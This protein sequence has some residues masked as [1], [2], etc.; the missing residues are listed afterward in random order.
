MDLGSV[1]EG[2]LEEILRF[3]GAKDG[4]GAAAAAAL[5]RDGVLGSVR[6]DVP[7]A[8][9]LEWRAALRLG[10]ARERAFAFDPFGAGMERSRAGR[11]LRCWR[12]DVDFKG[13]ARPF[14]FYRFAPEWRADEALA[15]EL[16]SE[17]SAARR[18]FS[19]MME[20]SALPRGGDGTVVLV[21][22][23][24]TDLEKSIAGH[25]NFFGP[26]QRWRDLAEL[27]DTLE[28]LPT[29]L[30][31]ETGESLDLDGPRL[32]LMPWNRLPVYLRP[33]DSAVASI[34]MGGHGTTQSVVGVAYPPPGTNAR[35]P[36]SETRRV[37]HY[38]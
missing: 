18:G 5:V 38:Y 20:I 29:H 10:V 12:G 37:R 28:M 7:E 3:V 27:L 24:P 33:A 19:R 15:L 26:A 11:W 23:T 25:A 32:F 17:L 31:V 9:G 2:L 14:A 36:R 1:P 16:P 30:C 21:L 6:G 34:Y 22:N 13:N 4:L 35:L 8:R